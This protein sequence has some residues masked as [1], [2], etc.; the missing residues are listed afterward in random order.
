LET[1]FRPIPITILDFLG[2]L[3]PG[4]LWLIL[5]VKFYNIFTDPAARLS[6][7][8]DA[9]A[10]INRLAS[11]GSTWLGPLSVIFAALVVG[12]ALKPLAMTVAG[13]LCRPL[14]GLSSQVRGVPWHKV[15]FPFN[16]IYENREYYKKVCEILSATTGVIA[17]TQL[18]GT[19]PFVAAKRYLRATA[20]TLWEESE[21]ME[22]EVRMTGA[23]F[24]G[25]VFSVLLNVILA[26]SGYSGGIVWASLSFLAAL[27]LAF[28]FNILRLREVSYTYLNLLLA[29]GTQRK[30]AT[31]GKQ[32]SMMSDDD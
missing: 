25:A 12:Y 24:L 31:L 4:F 21:R 29:E 8:V 13:I 9:W 22:A 6:G 32:S 27:A 19:A 23:L 2:V 16:A 11:S 14:F 18:P 17:A 5:I 10:R 20:P 15:V 7:V 1:K 30:I 28:G 3:V 26:V